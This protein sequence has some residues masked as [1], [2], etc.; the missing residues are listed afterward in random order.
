[1]RIPNA[2]TAQNGLRS[3]LM[4]NSEER[5]YGGIGSRKL[6]DGEIGRCFDIG[7]QRALESW[8]LRTG[9]AKGADQAF[10]EG[11]LVVRGRVVL[12]LPWASYEKAWV[13]WAQRHGAEVEVLRNR[14]Q[15]A[16]DSVTQ[17]HPAA[18]RLTRGVRAMHAR[19]FVI[20]RG[21]EE[22]IAWPKKDKYGKYGGTGQGMRIA[23]AAGV[24]LWNL[25]VAA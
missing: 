6:N 16:W 22:C 13:E 2:T 25:E 5:I 4:I 24:A 21:C 9:A 23:E 19:N 11:A 17:Y 15:E 14:D 3:L 12:C 1:M 18:S 8:I 20:L 7:K 10:A